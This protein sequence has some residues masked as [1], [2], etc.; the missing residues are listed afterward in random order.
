[1]RDAYLKTRTVTLCINIENTAH[2]WPIQFAKRRLRINDYKSNPCSL[3]FNRIGVV[4]TGVAYEIIVLAENNVAQLFV[5]K[6]SH[7]HV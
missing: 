4:E 3:L 6:V 5:V 7:C 1:M 2:F